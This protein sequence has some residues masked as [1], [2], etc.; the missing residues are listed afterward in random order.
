MIL[1]SCNKKLALLRTTVSKAMD[2]ISD[3]PVLC[4]PPFHSFKGERII[5]SVGEGGRPSQTKRAVC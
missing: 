5:A 4:S 3:L 1:D 2:L